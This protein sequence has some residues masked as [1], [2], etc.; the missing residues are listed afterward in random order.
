MDPLGTV[1]AIHVA[2]EAGAPMRPRETVEA[3]AGRGLRGDRYFAE[4]GTYSA[5]A[6][7]T[8]RDLTLIEAETIEAL[9]REAGI[10]LPAGAHRRNLTTRGVA[11]DPLVG[12]RFRVG[13]VVCE[14]VEPCAP[15]S[16]LERLLDID[17][18]HDALVD[19]GGLRARIVDSGRIAVG[20]GISGPGAD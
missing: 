3:I 20:D 14:G 8:A 19:R 17:G 15:C 16:Y 6:R 13:A 12:E 10:D 4:R 18:L 5:S 2:P 9:E 7:R 11:L 1:R